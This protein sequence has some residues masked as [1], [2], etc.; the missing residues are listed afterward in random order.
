MKYQLF[1][2]QETRFQCQETRSYKQKVFRLMSSRFQDQKQSNRA[3]AELCRF[4]RQET[5]SYS[6]QQQE[7]LYFIGRRPEAIT[8]SLQVPAAD[9]FKVQRCHRLQLQKLQKQV[10]GFQQ[11]KT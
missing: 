4:Q 7:S 1:D 3:K 10:F 9:V 6:S 11:Q 2:R 8:A 5:R